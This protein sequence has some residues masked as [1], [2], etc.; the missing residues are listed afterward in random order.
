MK[1]RYLLPLMLTTV[2]CQE[3][4]EEKKPIEITSETIL[5]F[6]NKQADSTLI[7]QNS[8]NQV[9]YQYFANYLTSDYVQDASLAEPT[10]CLNEEMFADVPLSASG[11]DVSYTINY[12]PS[13]SCR[14]ALKA[15]GLADLSISGYARYTVP[16]RMFVE[17]HYACEKD[18]SALN[19]ASLQDLSNATCG[20]LH[21][22]SFRNS[23]DAETTLV[24]EENGKQEELSYPVATERL[25]MGADG[26]LCS[27]T[28]NGD[29]VVVD[30]GCVQG[31]YSK[32]GP[33]NNTTVIYFLARQ[34]ELTATV[35]PHIWYDAGEVEVDANNWTGTVTYQGGD[36]APTYDMKNGKVEI[37]G[38]LS[39]DAQ[40]SVSKSPDNLQ[41]PEL[42]RG[43]L[44]LGRPK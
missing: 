43:P 27:E 14:D 35:G 40:L 17:V 23:M 41:L 12:S 20:V 16:T 44:P 13:E 19:G 36:S 30:S 7:P 2:A 21:A 29:K 25:R 3:K 1:S 33:S 22:T 18:V 28:Q 37:K 11:G 38:S 34:R 32:T 31:I 9:F 5:G 42:F 15:D 4:V 10:N 6:Q 39:S 8:F 26:G 24:A